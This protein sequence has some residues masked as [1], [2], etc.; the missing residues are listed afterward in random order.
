VNFLFV[1]SVLADPT[2][3]TVASLRQLEHG[4]VDLRQEPIPLRSGEFDVARYVDR[5]NL[6]EESLHRIVS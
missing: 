4:L 1:Y 6:G 3:A 5:L 2:R